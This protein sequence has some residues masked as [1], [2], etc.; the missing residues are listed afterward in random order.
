MTRYANSGQPWSDDPAQGIVGELYDEI[1]R[2]LG[3]DGP[4]TTFGHPDETRVGHLVEDDG[5][6]D[7]HAHPDYLAEDSGDLED[8][9]AEELAMHFVSED[10]LAAETDGLEDGEDPGMSP[11]LR[12]RLRD[13]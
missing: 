6:Y 4:I 11:G 8:L 3:T 5:G 2:D 1:S 9:S 13:A 10:D 7:A 12:A